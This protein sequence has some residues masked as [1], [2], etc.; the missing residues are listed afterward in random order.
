VVLCV[1]G[2]KSLLLD[3][4]LARVTRNGQDTKRTFDNG[5]FDDALK[6]LTRVDRFE[7]VDPGLQVCGSKSGFKAG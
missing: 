3:L 2:C 5:S 7:D 1:R 6:I 4:W